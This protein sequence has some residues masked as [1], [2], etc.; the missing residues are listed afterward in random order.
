MRIR[1]D[2]WSVVAGVM[3]GVLA[4]TVYVTLRKRTG[5]KGYF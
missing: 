5:W 2:M 3:L 1:F 4:A